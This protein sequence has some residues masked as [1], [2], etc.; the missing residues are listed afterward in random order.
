MAVWPSLLLALTLAAAG[1]A[2]ALTDYDRTEQQTIK[3]GDKPA[4]ELKNPDAEEDEQMDDEKPG[5]PMPDSLVKKPGDKADDAQD[6][7]D[8]PAIPVEIILDMNQLPEPVKKLRIAIV[9]AAASGDIERLRPL[10]KNGGDTTQVSVGDA[11]EDPIAALK[12]LSGDKEGREVL[13]ILLDIISTGAAHVDKGTPNELYVWPYF[14]E[15]SLDSLTPPEIVELYRIVTAADV[16]DMK[17]FG[18][19]NFY[20][21]GISP[22]GKW[23][24]FVA[25]D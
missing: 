5:L 19:Y 2:R 21:I 22:D 4:D 12:S 6:K 20:R 8:E 7:A 17:E 3:G 1:P 23:K 9:E 13:G 25:G 14:A 10:M 18:S 24:F 15:K 11:P 16:A